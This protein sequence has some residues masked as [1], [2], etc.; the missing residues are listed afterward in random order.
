VCNF[1]FPQD[2]SMPSRW[3]CCAIVAFWLVANGWLLWKD[4]WPRFRPGQPPPFSIDLIDEVQ[5]NRPYFLWTVLQ[6]DRKVFR[7]Q[8]WMRRRGQDDFELSAEYSTQPNFEP[9]T[10]SFLKI[11]RLK[12]TY[13]MTTSGRLL[14]LA[15][16]VEATPTIAKLPRLD[17][18]IG[19]MKIS[20]SGEVENGTLSPTVT[21]HNSNNPQSLGLPKAVVPDDGSIL[22]PLHP[23]NR[24]RGIRPGL[25]WRMPVM[26]P[27]ADSVGAMQGTPAGPRF[28]DA[29]VRKDVEYF[30]WGAQ[31]DVPCF[32]IDY[33][34]ED[35]TAATW[36][37]HETGVVMRQ[38]AKLDGHHWVINRD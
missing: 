2:L 13:R 36:V 14:S 37:H 25:H 20:I 17:R 9:A 22:M 11:Q 1:I 8:T 35:I 7:G 3:I 19:E 31:V 4:L 15:V 30:T 33:T 34:G 27:L 6:D 18:L 16:D 29:E 24:V 23:V 32:V 38:E 5:T 10:I 12:S 28:L 26:D 21:L